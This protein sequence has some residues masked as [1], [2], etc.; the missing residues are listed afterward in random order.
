MTSK[1]APVDLDVLFILL[2]RI[3]DAA[4]PGTMAA[5]ERELEQASL[6]SA[7]SIPT[8]TDHILISEWSP[9]VKP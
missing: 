8:A 7:V 6:P 1:E 9:L 2:R 5:L 3:L 4:E